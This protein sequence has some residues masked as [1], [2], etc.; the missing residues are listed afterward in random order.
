LKDLEI[1]CSNYG[2]QSDKFP[3]DLSSC[4]NVESVKFL[5]PG[6]L[7]IPGLK[8]CENLRKNRKPLLKCIELPVSLDAFKKE[9]LEEFVFLLSG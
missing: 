1:W 9:E 8:I 7:S 3:V 2:L 4:T 5:N 6:I